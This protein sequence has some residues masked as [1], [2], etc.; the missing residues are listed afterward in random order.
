MR[1]TLWAHLLTL[2]QSLERLLFGSTNGERNGHSHPMEMPS[3]LNGTERSSNVETCEEDDRRS[4]LP[5]KES[6][7][8]KSLPLLSS[9]ITTGSLS[10]DSRHAG[11]GST[12]TR[13]DIELSGGDDGGWTLNV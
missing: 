2:L 5:M 4:P 13:P 6:P 12:T 10:L 7:P 8:K 3:S 11:S 1:S 9:T